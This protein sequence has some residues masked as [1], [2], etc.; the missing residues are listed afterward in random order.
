VAIGLA[1]APAAL[2][3]AITPESGG[4]PNADSIDTL[5][6]ITLAIAIFIF[7]LVEGVLAWCLFRY[8]ARKGRSAA[9]IHGNT[10]LEIG[11][12]VGAALILVVLATVTFVKLGGIQNPPNSEA[13]GLKLPASGVLSA[14]TYVP[15]PPNGRAL[16]ICVVGRQYI[17]RY[18]YSRCAQAFGKPYSY[19]EMVVPAKTTVVLDITST[20]VNHSW[21]IPKL[22]GKFDAIQGYHNYTWFRAPTA[23]VVYRGQCAE[24]CGRNHANMTARVRV[25]SPTVFGAWLA[26][27]RLLI[28]QAN[29]AVQVDRRLLQRAGELSQQGM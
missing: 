28:Q 6:K 10:N 19:E 18:T 8:R 20:D 21:W 23:G 26:R 22:G 25:V 4:S 15:E 12:T 16:H 27:Q 5:Y 29:R 13:G 24:L 1:V 2:A 11:W 14:S 3:D 17:W 9:Q 7:L